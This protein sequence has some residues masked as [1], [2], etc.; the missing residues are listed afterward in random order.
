MEQFFAF[1]YHIL[2]TYFFRIYCCFF[3]FHPFRTL[4]IWLTTFKIYFLE[5]VIKQLKWIQKEI[6]SSIDV[7]KPILYLKRSDSKSSSLLLYV[8]SKVIN[9]ILSLFECIIRSSYIIVLFYFEV[10]K[11]ICQY[12]EVMNLN[13]IFH[14]S[15]F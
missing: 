2:K 10:I 9:S 11:L 8:L 1:C 6:N 4:F 14:V 13:W 12:F 15:D 7:S 3:V 5:F